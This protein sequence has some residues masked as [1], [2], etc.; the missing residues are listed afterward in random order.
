MSKDISPDYMFRRQPI[1]TVF[2]FTGAR[3]LLERGDLRL[4]VLMLLRRRPVHGYGLMKSICEEFQY[5]PSAGVIYPTLQLLQDMEY[6]KVAEENDK[7]IYS[8]TEEGIKHLENNHAIVR[9][10][11]A[12]RNQ[13]GRFVLRKD[14]LE[15]NRLLLLNY[16]YLS[17]RKIDKIQDAI[18]EMNRKIRE[19]I[20]EESP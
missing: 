9:R 6:V 2:P 1:G 15:T 4:L 8:I 11:E 20:F 19:I 17:H 10:I 5:Q 13:L 16:P 3:S 7:K 14:I 12:N 18:R